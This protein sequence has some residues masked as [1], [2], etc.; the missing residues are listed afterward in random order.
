MST[1]RMVPNCSHCDACKR[2]G[3]TEYSLNQFVPQE[4]FELTK[5]T[6]KQYTYI[7]DS[8][9]SPPNPSVPLNPTISRSGES[10]KI[11]DSD[12]KN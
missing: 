9:I 3:G 4:D 2:L 7:A 10:H 5:G 8:G 12:G 6:P 11:H 1:D